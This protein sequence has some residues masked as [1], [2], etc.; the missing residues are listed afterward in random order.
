MQRLSLTE[1][2]DLIESLDAEAIY[3]YLI[4]H[5]V[6]DKEGKEKIENGKNKVQRNTA[7]LQLVEGTGS[8]AV[9]LFINA[10][11]QSG[12]LHLASSLDED[13]RIKPI[14]GSGYLGKDRYKGQ[15]TINVEVDRI[16][17]M[18][19]VWEEGDDM[20]EK[21]G[22]TPEK[23]R[24]KKEGVNPVLTPRR[25]HKSYENMTMIG[26]EWSSR[27]WKI[28]E[29]AYDESDE[30]TPS[31]WCFCRRTKT[32][33]KS[34]PTKRK[35]KYE[36]K[37]EV[38]RSP[39]PVKPPKGSELP[40]N[41]RHEGPTI[42]RSSSRTSFISY[43]LST[44]AIN[45]L[46]DSH[47]FNRSV[48]NVQNRKNSLNH[49]TEKAEQFDSTNKENLGNH[50][51]NHVNIDQKRKRENL[52]LT[53]QTEKPVEQCL[54]WKHRGPT[55][56]KHVKRFYKSLTNAMNMSIIKYFEQK[57]GTLVLHVDMEDSLVVCNI[58]MTPK[59]VT[60]VC[61]NLEDGSLLRVFESILV[62]SDILEDLAVH[63][64]KLRVVIDSD[65]LALAKQ[66][67]A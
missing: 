5:G 4:Q 43:T 15:V 12:Q 20:E 44:E 42:I 37:N 11:R 34:I 62:T 53:L 33:K 50:T 46:K 54:K 39:S 65:E 25:A 19:P 66:E 45:V 6:L 48:E 28:R 22:D 49:N 40:K 3:D 51:E 14:Y 30:D 1:R 61:V 38:T 58:C 8:S 7:L 52:N 24:K 67:L 59:Q 23:D 57:R 60:D 47:V 55:F 32:K 21:M 63:Q 56:E 2:E 27:G 18:F 16:F 64:I 31:C 26:E 29:Y 13:S 41:L 35:L 10:L 36:V 17:G 9:A